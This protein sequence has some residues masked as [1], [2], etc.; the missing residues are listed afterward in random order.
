MSRTDIHRPEWV[1]RK[2]E[3]IRHWFVEYHNHDDGICDLATFLDAKG[4][5]R[6]RCYRAVS[7][8]CPNLCSCW[9]CGGGYVFHLA[10]KQERVLWRN[11]RQRALKM[12]PEDREDYDEGLLHG[13]AAW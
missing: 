11:A 1:L 2:D 5:V 8:A 3:T 9:M 7:A 4:W 12:T 6:T 13:S 10:Q